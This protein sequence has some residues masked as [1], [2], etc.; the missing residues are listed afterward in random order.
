MPTALSSFRIPTATARELAARLHRDLSALGSDVWL[1]RERF[2]GGDRW[3]REIETALDWCDVLVAFLSDGSFTSDPCR[4]EQGWAIDAGKRSFRSG[5]R[6][7]VAFS[8][9]YTVCSTTISASR[10][11]MTARFTN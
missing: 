11:A 5:Y 10:R 7:G 4:A 2:R 3:A 1:D 8:S 6:R 9:A